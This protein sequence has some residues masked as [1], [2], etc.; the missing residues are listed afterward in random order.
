MFRRRHRPIKVINVQS[1][2]IF[3]RYLLYNLLWGYKQGHYHSQL[4]LPYYFI[5]TYNYCIPTLYLLVP[6]LATR[7][8]QVAYHY[9][10]QSLYHPDPLGRLNKNFRRQLYFCQR[11]YTYI[12][13]NHSSLVVLFNWGPIVYI[14]IYRKTFLNQPTMELTLYG[15]FTEVVGLRSFYIVTMI[16]RQS[17][18][19]LIK[20]ST[21]GSGRPVKMAGQRGILYAHTHS[22]SSLFL[23]DK[24]G[25]ATR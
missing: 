4:F 19:T 12:L 5:L 6:V 3:H 21:Q 25:L 10:V 14:Y 8:P 9:T 13:L 24:I 1:W 15:P 17:F 2:T 16:Y 7:A 20:Q 22:Y 18:G 11:R 23:A